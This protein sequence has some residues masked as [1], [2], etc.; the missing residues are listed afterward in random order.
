VGKSDIWNALLNYQQFIH[1]RFVSLQYLGL[2]RGHN[3]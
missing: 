1:L 2:V 3:N